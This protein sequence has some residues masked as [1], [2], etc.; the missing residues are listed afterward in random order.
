MDW[1]EAHDH[2]IYLATLVRIRKKEEELMTENIKHRL[3]RFK[4]FQ[5]MVE[6]DSFM[7]K[8]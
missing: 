4:I 3:A 5:G 1:V 2:I 8:N 7:L 6:Y